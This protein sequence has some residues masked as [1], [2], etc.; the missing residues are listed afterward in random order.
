MDDQQPGTSYST[1]KRPVK[2]VSVESI[3]RSLEES[4]SEDDFEISHQDLPDTDSDDSSSV[5]SDE[6]E[7][8]GEEDNIVRDKNGWSKV[9]IP[10]DF[11]KSDI[12]FS[13][14][15][16][17]KSKNIPDDVKT[18]FDFFSLFLNLNILRI[19]VTE[20]N[21]Y[22][23]QFLNKTSTK[24]WLEKYPKSRYNKWPKE[25]I[26]L[27]Q[28]KK[29]LGL[30]L[31]MG[32]TKKK[33]LAHYWST[34]L[35]RATP[36][37]NKTMPYDTF[38]LISRMLHLNNVE[39]EIPRGAVGYD[40]WAKVR[41]FLDH[42]NDA[43]KYFYVPSKN[44][45]I[46]E[47]MVGMR[48][49]VLFI[50]YLPNKRHARFGIKKFELCD[51]NGYLIHTDLY[52]G[53]ELDV[54][55]VEGHAFGVVDKLMTVSGLLNK[56]YHLFTDNFYTKPKL[57]LHLL[58]QKTLLTGTVRSNSKDMPVDVTQKMNVG[59]SR[60]WQ[61]DKMLTVAF[62]EKKSQTRPVIALSTG[63]K[64]TVP[65][66]TVKGKE[67]KKPEIIFEYNKYMGGVDISDKQV[68][69][70]ASERSTRRYWKKI[71]HN[72]LDKSVLNAYILYCD[73][74]DD[75]MSR[76]NFLLDVIE[77]LCGYGDERPRVPVATADE[78]P[79]HKLVTLEGSKEKDC[80]V[81]NQRSKDKN[82]SS[83][84][85]RSRTWCPACLVGCH[86]KCEQNLVHVTNQGLKR[87]QR[88]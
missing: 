72:L 3:L 40:P 33:T 57:A 27:I 51:S 44:I 53:K 29:Y 84:R 76:D 38:V 2:N 49:R 78:P 34:R 15:N 19:I 10:E 74:T 24:A 65:T 45:S 28:I 80:F 66:R 37:F 16:P 85:K 30:I 43:C 4:D 56:G 13:V 62:R 54:Q 11:V 20:T 55:H 41:V 14:R 48:N 50:Q 79:E 25:G 21:R 36:F 7:G 71:F 75:P 73:A 67:K 64:A 1:S 63:H 6:S 86:K 23:R 88:D 9:E 31:N 60:F 61:N 26:S 5:E 83:G 18:P 70:L 17:Q 58:R 32:L 69:H 59:E 35:S 81:C 82:S 12:G 77:C 22:A 52:S 39:N 47:S 87:K 68:Y 42:V 8:E 46:D